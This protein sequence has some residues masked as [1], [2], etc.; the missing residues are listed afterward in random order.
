MF[1]DIS[2]PGS[3][4]WIKSQGTSTAVRF[5]RGLSQTRLN[6]KLDLFGFLFH[7][8]T[9]RRKKLKLDL[10]PLLDFLISVDPKPGT[11]NFL[12][13][14]LR[15]FFAKFVP[16][17]YIVSYRRLCLYGVKARTDLRD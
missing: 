14:G 15:R 16:Q 13:L 7:F 12:P 10:M 3:W 1:Y 17:I 4:H 8:F 11:G 6:F 5:T 9:R 2:T